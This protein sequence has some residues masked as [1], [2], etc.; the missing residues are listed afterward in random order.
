M[1]ICI[2]ALVVS[3]MVLPIGYASTDTTANLTADINKQ[4]KNCPSS[5]QFEQAISSRTVKPNEACENLITAIRD[6]GEKHSIALSEGNRIQDKAREKVDE[7][8]EGADFQGG[9]LLTAVTSA[10]A[11]KGVV[12]ELAKGIRGLSRAIGGAQITLR[13]MAKVRR[14]KALREGSARE[15]NALIERSVLM[16]RSATE[17]LAKNVKTV[18][19]LSQIAVNSGI[20]RAELPAEGEM[21]NASDTLRWTIDRNSSE[22]APG[23]REFFSELKA[24]KTGEREGLVYEQIENGNIPAH[25]EGLRPIQ[26]IQRDSRG[27]KHTVTYWTM[28]DYVGIGSDEDFVRM[29]MSYRW[30]KHT[31]N[32]F[33]LDIPTDLMVD[34]LYKQADIK[35]APRPLPTK[36]MAHPNAFERHHDIIQG[37]LGDYEL[38]SIPGGIKKDNIVHPNLSLRKDGMI[39]YGWH[40]LNGKRIQ[41]PNVNRMHIDYHNDYS[42]GLRPVAPFVEID[43][44]IYSLADAVEDEELAKLLNRRGAF[45]YTMYGY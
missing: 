44:E 45:P 12:I 18:S 11:E 7:Q 25:L 34:E 35:V 10:E 40:R 43:G 29:P 39:I 16:R 38:G 8:V 19:A 32:E 28:P 9:S 3:L 23:G 5:F 31:S 27:R 33:G 20:R 14:H 41:N 21:P 4:D 13:A 22:R 36:G 24:A 17:T 6:L 37:Q 2:Q 30:S 1:K 26:T 42:Q 15:L